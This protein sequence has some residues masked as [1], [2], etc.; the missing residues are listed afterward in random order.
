MLE[1]IKAII[2]GIVEGVTE[3]LPISSTGHLILFGKLLTLSFEGADAELAE[4]LRS[5]FDVV[6]QSGAILAVLVIYLKR[7]WR[8]PL[9]L[10]LKLAIATLP[11]GVIGILADKICEKCLGQSLDSLLFTPRVVA[12][13]LIGYGILFIL[14]ERL[15]KS[16][17]DRV[18]DVNAISFTQALAIGCFQALAIVPGTSR[19][20][21]TMLGARIL[22]VSRSAAAEFS[23]FAA[24]PVI[25]AA[26]ALKIY[27]LADYTVERSVAL[28]P[29]VIP[30]FA[31]SG[32]VAFA[33]SMISIKFLTEFIKK[34]SFAPF[35]IYRILLGALVLML[36]K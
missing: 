19:S 1:Y 34:H 8:A 33:V 31:L 5:S 14:V 30:T 21:A 4:L 18:S 7:L 13:A 23:F 11:T 12:A 2:L 32:A 10:Y 3:W 20:G 17:A 16:R 25:F 22:G 35:G 26:S 9:S 6:I 28:P 29:S 15:M 27:E 36:L 24:I